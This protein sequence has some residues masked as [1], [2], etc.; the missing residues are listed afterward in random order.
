M[1]PNPAPNPPDPSGWN[2]LVQRARRD[3]PAP[4]DLPALLRVVRAA[5]TSPLPVP[6]FLGEFAAL[7][8]TRQAMALCAAASFAC[9]ALAGWQ[10]WSAWQE[11]GPWAEFTQGAWEIVL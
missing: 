7:F 2:D 11:L 10:T 8:A 4:V 5:A 3:M 6:T 1:T 9:V